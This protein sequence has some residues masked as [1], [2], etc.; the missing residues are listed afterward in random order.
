VVKKWQIIERRLVVDNPW[1]QVY[2]DDM[3]TGTGVR[4]DGYYTVRKRDFAAVVPLTSDGQ[5]LLIREYK[6][7]VG[8][9]VW[10][11]P[12]GIVDQGEDAATAAARELH[13][14]TGYV[15]ASLEHLGTWVVSDAF[16]ADKAHLFVAYDVQASGAAQLEASEE[17]E[18][19]LMP[20]A[21]AIRAVEAGVLFSG[22]G[23][24]A[25]LLLAARRVGL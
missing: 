12:A 21:E 1:L 11:L 23:L 24:V 7:A 13:E 17:I 4:V 3:L 14:E 16:V 9:V 8:E 5:V 22:V 10:S 6:H 18:C 20:F 25:A 19:Q 15:A 2:E